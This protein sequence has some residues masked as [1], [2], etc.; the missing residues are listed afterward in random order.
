MI[1][2]EKKSMELSYISK[3]TGQ[4]ESLVQAG[5]GNTS[6]KLDNKYMLIKASGYQLSEITANSG[7]SI[8]DYNKISEAFEEGID[9]S[10]EQIILK[11]ALCKGKK[12]SIE[13]FLHSVT[14]AY[15]IHSHPLGVN[16]LTAIEGGM[17]QLK[18]MFPEAIC[19]DYATP[20]IKLAKKYYNAV[21]E[22]D[23]IDIVFLKNHGLIVSADSPEQVLDLQEKVVTTVDRYLGIDDGNISENIRLFKAV[24]SVDNSLIAYSINSEAVCLAVEKACGEWTYRFSP[25]CVVYCGKKFF[26]AD[27]EDNIYEKLSKYIDTYGMPKVCIVGK[28]VYVIAPTVRKAEEV[29]SML[30]FTAKM[31]IY[32]E[33]GKWDTLPEEEVDFLLDWD[34]EKYRSSFNS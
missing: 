7:Y 17:D 26:I 9:D 28:N 13:T 18:K 5:G 25:D 3:C 21:K 16:I 2:D 29:K 15:T 11:K 1:V 10:D 23:I 20:G 12:P 22:S 14:K 30:E 8:V 34:S 31:Y 24:N 32:S 6:V 19:V 4:C 27:R 33:N